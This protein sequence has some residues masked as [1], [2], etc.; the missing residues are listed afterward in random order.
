[1]FDKLK[2]A[3]GIEDRNYYSS[4]DGRFSLFDAAT[5]NAHL[6]PQCGRHSWPGGGFRLRRSGVSPQHASAGLCQRSPRPLLGSHRRKT[7]IRQRVKALL[8]IQG[9]GPGRLELLPISA[10]TTC[11]GITIRETWRYHP[12]VDRGRA[13]DQPRVQPPWRPTWFTPRFSFDAPRPWRGGRPTGNAPRLRAGLSAEVSSALARRGFHD[14]RSGVLPMPTRGDGLA[15]T[16]SRSEEVSRGV[17]AFVEAHDS[18]RLRVI[19]GRMPGAGW[20]LKRIGAAPPV[21][22]GQ[23]GRSS[24]SERSLV[25]ACGFNP[26]LFSDSD[27]TGAPRELPAGRSQA[28]SQPLGL[29]VAAELSAEAGDTE[30]SLDFRAA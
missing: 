25:A 5:G 11:A 26:R 15:G 2:Q 4:T 19:A 18:D 20:D 27:G 29:L 12:R 13:F 30:V 9:P 7:L 16:E 22:A 8:W 23:A 3:L 10:A 28:S 17:M 6:V 24:V 21:S 14:S 1:M